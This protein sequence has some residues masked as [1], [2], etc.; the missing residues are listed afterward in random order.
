ML[1]EETA[2]A[3]RCAHFAGF[4]CDCTRSAYRHDS[5]LDLVNRKNAGCE[6]SARGACASSSASADNRHD[7]AAR[8]TLATHSLG[9]GKRLLGP[10]LDPSR[11]G[12]A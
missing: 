6:I 4:D 3:I 1:V 2:L 11:H 9:N 12:D 8:S 5:Q 7:P 10:V